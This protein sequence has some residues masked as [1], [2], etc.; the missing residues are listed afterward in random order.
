MIIQIDHLKLFSDPF[1]RS[2][3]PADDDPAAKRYMFS[4]GTKER[5]LV[6][7]DLFTSKVEARASSSD[8]LFY[9]HTKTIEGISS[10]PQPIG[11]ADIDK[12]PEAFD[13][14]KQTFFVVHGWNNNHESAVNKIV[15]PALLGVVDANV[16]NVDWGSIAN[17]NYL[18]AQG[19][20]KE[21][22]QFV[23]Q[24]I[25]SLAEDLG[26]EKS[27]FS[28]IGHSLGAH[29][30]GN[31]GAFLGGEISVIIGLDPAGPL[32]TVSNTENRL[33][34]DD[35]RYVEIIHTCDG[36][37]GFTSSLGHVDFFPNGGKSQP[38]CGLDLI[39]TCAHSRSY[40]LFADSLINGKLV[41]TNCDSWSNFLDGKC[42]GELKAQIGL[43]VDIS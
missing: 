26:M 40:Q 3:D 18:T 35:A 17:R 12:V 6:V 16:F 7:E 31:A 29:V 9:L 43:S 21:I 33:D 41:G 11:V 36:L 30:C 34:P 1:P 32:F 10:A 2:Y 15:T 22:G 5:G 8:V 37:L 14:K 23:G 27:L 38:G 24:F 28:C 39:G 13:P 19:S 42:K 20:V 4:V 25:A